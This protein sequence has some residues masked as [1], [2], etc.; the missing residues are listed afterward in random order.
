LAGFLAGFFIGFGF[1]PG[2]LGRPVGVGVV[3]G[4]LA[5]T[6][7]VGRFGVGLLLIVVPRLFSVCC[8]AAS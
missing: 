8:L 4:P 5:I 2:F 3:P 1:L 6:K 7:A